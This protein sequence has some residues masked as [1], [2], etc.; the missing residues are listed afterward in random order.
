[1]KPLQGKVNHVRHT[2]PANGTASQTSPTPDAAPDNYPVEA[3][4]GL[5][6]GTLLATA[7][8]ASF[9]AAVVLTQAWVISKHL[10]QK[11]VG[12]L[13]ELIDDAVVQ[14]ILVLLK[15]TS[16]VVVDDAG[17]VRQ[18]EVRSLAAGLGWLRLQERSRL[19]QVIGV[20][21]VFER[22]VRRLGEHGLFLQNRQNTHG[23]SVARD[24]LVTSEQQE[25]ENAAYASTI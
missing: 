14:R 8:L 4:H 22:L 25:R 3:R 16:D 13:L 18:T 15:P 6:G 9:A 24:V 21:L 2:L 5:E 17:I 12:A 11:L 7:A 10:D 1:M 19:A 20:Q 23:L